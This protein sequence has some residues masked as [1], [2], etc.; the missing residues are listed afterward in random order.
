MEKSKGTTGEDIG[1]P[2]PWGEGR[3]QEPGQ[4]VDESVRT[5]PGSVPN[6]DK[7]R[8]TPVTQRDYESSE[9]ASPSQDKCE[10]HGGDAG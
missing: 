7:R 1:R 10:L 5:P 3:Y 8:S 4:S 2:G 9:T 6:A